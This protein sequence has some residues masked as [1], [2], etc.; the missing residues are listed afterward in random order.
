MYVLLGG[1]VRGDVFGEIKRATYAKR[2]CVDLKRGVMGRAPWCENYTLP[3][4]TLGVLQ[5]WRMMGALSC[6]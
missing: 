6:A 4:A 3:L 5:C 2:S 1:A